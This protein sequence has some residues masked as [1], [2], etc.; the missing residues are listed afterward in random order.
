M[1]MSMA[2]P[3]ASSA[4][5]NVMVID[6][7]AGLLSAVSSLLV[8]RGYNATGYTSAAEALAELQDPMR[9]VDIVISD[10]RMPGMDGME[11]LR[12]VR[13]TPQVRATPVV[14]LS[15]KSFTTDRIEGYRAG[16]DAYLTK[17]FDP[18]ELLSIVD[19]LLVKRLDLI[20]EISGLRSDI[21]E[22]RNLVAELLES[23]GFKT[24]QVVFKRPPIYVTP[25][26]QE[27]LD[28]IAK[29]YMNR[30]IAEALSLSERTV[31][32]RVSALLEKTNTVNRT[33]LVRYALDFNLISD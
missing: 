33:E 17:P 15:A 24:S 21:Q 7:D 29:G 8:E 13:Q 3:P 27:V 30:E 19:N 32:K 5:Y 16:V 10:I 14:F 28:F 1:T 31:E 2:E 22:L 11:L 23:G 12:Q 25:R 9:R 6:D 18:E 4:M 20:A 26:E